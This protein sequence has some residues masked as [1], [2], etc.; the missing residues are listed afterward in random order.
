MA[1]PYRPGDPVMI[2]PAISGTGPKGGQASNG[3]T[4]PL[5][6]LLGWHPDF[7]I[8]RVLGRP[9][10]HPKEPV[11]VRPVGLMTVLRFRRVE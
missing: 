2:A 1:R 11:Q 9:G 4:A 7:A 6:D 10:L 3:R 5:A 8:D